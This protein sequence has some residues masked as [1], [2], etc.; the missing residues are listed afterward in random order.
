MRNFYDRLSEEEKKKVVKRP[1][2]KTNKFGG[3]EKRRSIAKVTLPC[4][5]CNIGG[6]NVNL[7]SEVVEVDFCQLVGNT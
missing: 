2:N 4:N 1:R 3:G 5:I 6:S 7:T